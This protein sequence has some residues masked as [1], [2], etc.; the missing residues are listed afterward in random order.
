[1]TVCLASFPSCRPHPAPASPSAYFLSPCSPPPHT[2]VSLLCPG[3][4]ADAQG[5][6]LGA[7]LLLEQ[8]ASQDPKAPSWQFLKGRWAALQSAG[9]SGEGG[10]GSGAEEGARL[11]WVISHAA[12][13]FPLAEADTLAKE[14]M[15]VRGG[16][17]GHVWWWGGEGGQ[18]NLAY[19][20]RPSQLAKD[21]LKE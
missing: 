8:V 3:L 19:I 11:L 9:G 7:W 5:T 12:T 18:G 10:R 21:L 4:A 17:R 14:L 1:M 16:G 2:P 15:Q 13:R 20:G 6:A